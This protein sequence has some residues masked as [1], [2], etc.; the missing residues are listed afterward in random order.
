MRTWTSNQVNRVQRYI[1][2]NHPNRYKRT[3]YRLTLDLKRINREEQRTIE[4]AIFGLEERSD[5]LE[6]L[7]D[8]VKDQILPENARF[9]SHVAREVWEGAL[10]VIDLAEEKVDQTC[11]RYFHALEGPPN[12]IDEIMVEHCLLMRQDEMVEQLVAEHKA[13]EAFWYYLENI[14]RLSER[15]YRPTVAM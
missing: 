10:E 3:S 8:G 4:A 1:A 13:L 7:Y 9:V 14:E 2:Y 12:E 11:V 5:L 15:H 6:Q